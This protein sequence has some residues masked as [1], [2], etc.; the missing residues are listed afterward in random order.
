MISS[1]TGYGD[2]QHS[3]D[4]VGYAIEIR[5]LNNRYLK[6]SI[7]LPEHLQYLEGDVEKVL[8]SRIVRG[9][10]NCSIRVRDTSAQAAYEI[11]VAA[12]QAYLDQLAKVRTGGAA[13]IDLG[14]V[15]AL[16][17]VCQPPEL[18][19][20]VREQQWA[21]IERLLNEALDKLIA[22]RQ[23]EG[24]AL[25]EDLLRHIDAIT[26]DLEAVTA[27][28]PLVI[29]EYH[30]RLLSRVNELVG[31]A[32]LQLEAADLAK[33]VALFAE[34]CDISEEI[35]RLK[36]H[37]DQFRKACD[38][39]QHAGRK[40]EFITQEMLREANTIASKSNDAAV[41]RHVVEIKGHIDR[42]KEQVQNV[43]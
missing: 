6:P 35:A 38:G 43:E 4:G 21:I 27:R 41:A 12:L 33:E 10:V 13:S 2:A 25:R 23:A 36:S 39:K 32:K 20:A 5:S 34:R 8:R 9:S 26:A 19:E 31:N 42:L 16:P 11:N 30:K 1:M 17:G 24:Q 18:D 15:L 3:T 29:E 37:M 40:L 7:K 14:T 28:A 22:M